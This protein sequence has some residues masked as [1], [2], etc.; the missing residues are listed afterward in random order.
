V[1]LGGAPVE[2]GGQWV[3]P[4]QTRFLDLITELGLSLF[5]THDEGRHV[6]ELNGRMV[7]C[8]GR[9]PRLNPAVLAG[10]GFGLWRLDRAVRTADTG[11]PVNARATALDAQTFAT[12]IR[13]HV[14]TRL[15]RNYL[16]LITKVVFAAEPE[17]LSALR[18]CSYI[19]AAGGADNLI[20]TAGGAQQDR[21]VGGSQQIALRLAGQLCDSIHL[22]CP[23]IEVDWADQ[24]VCLR[25]VD[26]T[27]LTA[28]KAIV[29]LPDSIT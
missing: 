16:R 8:T 1:L 14:H 18:V 19:A 2:V 5:P 29:A 4:G 24:M 17:D 13:R 26:S 23:V 22:N 28:W 11:L 9:I 6:A 7:A 25:L 12:W 27:T 10:I 3:G 20:I 15:A 21:I